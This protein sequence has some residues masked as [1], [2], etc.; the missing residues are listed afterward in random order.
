MLDAGP[1][2]VQGDV[3]VVDHL[4]CPVEAVEAVAL[5]RCGRSASKPRCDAACWT[6]AE[7]FDGAKDPDRVT[8]RRDTYIG[9]Q[10]T[11]LD[12]RGICQHS[13]LCTDRLASVFHV[14]EGPFVSP[15]G[16]R[17]DDIVRAAR[18]CPSGALSFAV[19][20]IEARTQVDW[21][22]SRQPTIEVTK[23]GP[24]R[25][26]G[27]V[28][29]VDE[30]EQPVLRDEGSSAE[31][32]ALCRCGHSQNKPFC[33]GMHFHV[34]FEDPVPMPDAAPTIFQW[35]GG[36]PALLRMTRIFYERYVPAD[37]LLGPLF[38]NM[39]ADHP[40][41][42]AQWLGEVF[43]GPAGYSTAH[44]G[45]SRMLS[46][47]RGR[48]LTEEQR[49]R[50]VQLLT[51]SAAEARLPNDA[52]FRSAFGAYLEWG[53]RLAVENSQV[54]SR[55]PEHMPMP[56]WTWDTAAGPPGSRISASQ[57]APVDQPEAPLV[58][59]A[60][61]EPV[62]FDK[63]VK[64]LFRAQDRASMK[65]AFDLWDYADV[66]THAAAIRDRVDAGTMPCDGAWPAEKVAIFNRWIDEGANP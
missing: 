33:S 23:D 35:A 39:S 9:Q 45:Y 25:V 51:R 57:P 10:V 6:G 5:C 4:G 40:Q 60:A 36:L 47:H 50:W 22:D 54:D 43:G 17:M 58:V 7:P 53:S 26:S 20:G 24:Y 12:N 44:G 59:P 64:P 13:G 27:G 8:D 30:R 55:P 29:L 48:G 15:S 63:H 61:D 49:A 62:R 2:V 52:E 56:H 16:G 37:D 18:D 21:G 3:S 14:G 65:F 28:E 66:H 31:H 41:R 1:L 38:A 11:V 34:N 42:V 32:C 19:D 46:Q